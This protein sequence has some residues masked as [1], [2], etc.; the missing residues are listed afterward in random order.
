MPRLH[1]LAGA[2]TAVLALGLLAAA[3]AAGQEPHV[4][5]AHIVAHFALNAGQTPENIALEADGSADLTFAFARQVAH[6]APDGGTRILV[7]LPDVPNPANPLVHSAI[8]TGI[9]RAHD[10]TL[11]VGYATGT[12]KT[13]IW[14]LVPGEAPEQITEL[15]PTGFPD[16]LA[17]DE[18]GG[19]LYAADSVLGTIW[20]IPQQG[21]PATAWAKGAALDPL[22]EPARGFGANGIKVRRD[23]VWV[24]N[25]DRGALLRVPVR[26]DGT[27]GPIE[28]RATGLDGIDDFAFPGTGTTVLAATSTTDALLLVRPN[29]RSTALLSGRNGLSNPTSV[30]VGGGTVYVTSAAYFTQRDPNL[31]LARLR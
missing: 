10:G 28:T 5:D 16:G 20:R 30:A 19:V 7:T 22:P 25:T 21:G 8:V 2:A 18:H 11:Y 6:V 14:R 31:V 13:G 3:P 4:G 29:G 24:S 1:R 23:A 12:R 15:P 17:L 27:A 26:A 9:A